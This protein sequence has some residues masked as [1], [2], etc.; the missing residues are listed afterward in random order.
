M[1]PLLIYLPFGSDEGS[2][3]VEL[4]RN[5]QAST[6]LATFTGTAQIHDGLTVLKVSPDLSGFSPGTYVLSASREGGPVWKCRFVLK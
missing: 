4:L 1:A 6:P 2:Y 5:E 3:T